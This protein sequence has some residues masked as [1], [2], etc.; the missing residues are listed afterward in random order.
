MEPS[1]QVEDNQGKSM[2]LTGIA[3]NDGGKSGKAIFENIVQTLRE[4]DEAKKELY[5]SIKNEIGIDPE[6]FLEKW[7]GEREDKRS[8]I[9]DLDM[10]LREI[11]ENVLQMVTDGYSP[12]QIASFLG[13]YPSQVSRILKEKEKWEKEIR[14]TAQ[15]QVARKLPWYLR[16]ASR[17]LS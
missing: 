7:L 11:A 6:P 2:K 5:R 9:E 3:G 12:S 14:G 1:E 10:P 16:W 4:N 8:K 13:I 15:K 17:F